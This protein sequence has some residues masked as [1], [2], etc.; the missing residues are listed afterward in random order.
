[1]TNKQL[2]G[3]SLEVE[4]NPNQ[5]IEKNVLIIDDAT[6]S[7]ATLNVTAQKIQT[8]SNHN[9]KVIRYSFSSREL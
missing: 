4:L 8:L 3:F 5:V 7:G 1:M 2:S 9:I 6:G